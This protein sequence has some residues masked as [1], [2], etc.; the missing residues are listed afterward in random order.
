MCKVSLQFQHPITSL[1]RL[2]SWVVLPGQ[3]MTCL[4]LIILISNK[5]LSQIYPTE[6]KLNN[7]NSFDT[8]AFVLD[9]DLSITNSLV[10]SFMIN[11]MILILK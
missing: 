3:Q 11:G 1:C 8:E 10:A 5:W 4:I 6:L 9:L 7:A 2:E